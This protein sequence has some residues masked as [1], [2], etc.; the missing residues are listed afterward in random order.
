[1]LYEPGGAVV[2][3]G[4]LGGLADELDA[5]PISGGI[6][7]LLA[8]EAR[9]TPFAAAFEVLDV[10]DAGE[11]ALRSWVRRAGIGTLEIKKRGVELDPAALRRR[12]K[13]SGSASA[14]LVVTPTAVG[15]RALVV[16]RL[17]TPR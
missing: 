8:A 9:P 4:A 2:R 3:S 1:M 15:L 5:A 16:R 7:Y 6:A 14:T 11:A 17:G 10:L 12:L 13:P